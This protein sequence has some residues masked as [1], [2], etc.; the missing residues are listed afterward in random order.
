MKLIFIV[1]NISIEEDVQNILSRMN[2]QCF[3]QW[4]RLLGKG[5]TTGPRMD[6][7]VWPGANSALMAVVE[8]SQ[9]KPLM[10]AVQAL[11]DGAAKRE[12]IKA[13]QLPVEAMTGNL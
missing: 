12:G 11:R 7:S 8:D 2:V 3:T 1:Y 4:P 6:T 10:D 13:F 9:A 5:I